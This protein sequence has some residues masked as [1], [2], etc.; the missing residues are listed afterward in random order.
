MASKKR[1]S[2]WSITS[3]N[4]T[5][6]V[7]GLSSWKPPIIMEP[8]GI[9]IPCSQS[10]WASNFIF[11]SYQSSTKCQTWI[12]G[13]IMIDSIYILLS[14]SSVFFVKKC[15]RNIWSKTI[16]Q[17]S[18]FQPS[19]CPKNIRTVEVSTWKNPPAGIPK[20]FPSFRVPWAP[21]KAP[22]TV[23]GRSRYS[24]C[25]SWSSQTQPGRIACGKDQGP[26]ADPMADP[27]AF[28]MMLK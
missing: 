15:V 7:F 17:T 25:S 8:C 3:R 4:S 21:I 12:F 6:V 24:E 18:N 9:W 27:M 1:S 22:E 11:I 5:G 13:L 23:F 14:S 2:S 20:G 28:K 19:Q 10:C 26:M 16:S